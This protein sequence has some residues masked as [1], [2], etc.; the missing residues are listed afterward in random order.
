MT[1][2]FHFISKYL[3]FGRDYWVGTAHLDTTRISVSDE[4]SRASTSPRERSIVHG[5]R[6]HQPINKPMPTNLETLH[7]VVNGIIP[8][9]TV[10]RLAR[11]V[12]VD[13]PFP[14]LPLL[15]LLTPARPHK[16]LSPMSNL[17]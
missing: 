2:A 13:P 11:S 1:E 14:P 3:I 5:Q 15:T 16:L 10:V 4:S 8:Y 17:R 6:G 9:S 12:R 7:K